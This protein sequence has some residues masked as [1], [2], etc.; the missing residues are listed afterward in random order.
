MEVGGRNEKLE[1]SLRGQHISSQSK[2]ISAG[3]V[4]TTFLRKVQNKAEN[5]HQV[6]VNPATYGNILIL[7]VHCQ[8]LFLEM[9]ELLCTSTREKEINLKQK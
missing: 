4:C 2:S 5:H 9:D 7:S 6:E 8:I 1:C 3:R